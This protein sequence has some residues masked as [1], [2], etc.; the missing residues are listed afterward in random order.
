MTYASWSW[1]NH[2]KIM[3]RL[4]RGWSSYSAPCFLIILWAF[5]ALPVCI[6]TRLISLPRSL[7]RFFRVTGPSERKI[8]ICRLKVFGLRNNQSIHHIRPRPSF[9]LITLLNSH[10]KVLIFSQVFFQIPF[11]NKLWS[12]RNKPPPHQQF[13]TVE[14]LFCPLCFISISSYPADLSAC[15]S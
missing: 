8:R 2:V 10:S 15:F 6:D 9:E 3:L 5:Y 13:R 7:N 14:I 4:F 1:R 11:H 12:K